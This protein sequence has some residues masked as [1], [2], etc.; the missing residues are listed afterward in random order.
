MLKL[1]LQYF[2]HLMRR[3]DSLEK[4]LLMGKIEGRGEEDERGWDGWMG[5]L[6]Q[7]TWKWSLVRLFV[8]LW[9]AARQASLSFTISWSL[10]KFISITMSQ[11]FA[12]ETQNTGA[13]AS[14][15]ASVLPRSIQIWFPLRFTDL[16]SLLSEGLSGLFSSTT[17]Q[18]HQFFGALLLCSLTFTTIG[19]HSEDH[20][21][22]YMNLC[23]LSNISAFQH[24]V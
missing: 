18:R 4:T 19:N 1:K 11:L 14:A 13:S 23:W 15:S 12:S 20:S 6:T 17:V 21:L 7:L 16:I 2:V 8:T 3:A 5:S 9:T 22:D 24:T 10:P